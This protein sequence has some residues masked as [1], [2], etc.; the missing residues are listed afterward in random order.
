MVVWGKAQASSQFW[1]YRFCPIIINL[2]E[3]VH[4]DIPVEKKEKWKQT[5]K[6]K[7]RGNESSLYGWTKFDTY[8]IQW[9][10]V[11]FCFFFLLW[12]YTTT[13]NIFVSFFNDLFFQKSYE[14]N[15]TAWVFVGMQLLAGVCLRLFKIKNEQL[16]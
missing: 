4:Y 16:I 10:S 13:H 6:Q 8:F 14:W 15:N 7:T 11:L 9:E 3:K 1:T 2:N 5:H 12:Y